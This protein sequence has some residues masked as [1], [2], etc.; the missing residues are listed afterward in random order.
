MNRLL[1]LGLN[2][3]T[4]PLEVREKLAFSAEERLAA[5]ASLRHQF[6]DSEAVILS[7]CNRIE[8]YVSRPVHGHPRHEEMTAF[9]ASIRDLPPQDFNSHVYAKADRDAVTHL[10]SVA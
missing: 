1:L 6:A 4:A 10:F 3:L 8:L 7:T 2:H 9:I 5:L